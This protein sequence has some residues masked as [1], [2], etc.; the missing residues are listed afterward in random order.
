MASGAGQRIAEALAET[1]RDDRETALLV[2]ELAVGWAAGALVGGTPESGDDGA[3]ALA[4]LSALDDALTE[5]PALA[6]ALPVLLESARAGGQLRRSAEELT[7]GLAALAE[8]VTAERER[9][10]GLRAGEAA[11]R[12]RVAEHEELRR[13]AAELER[14]TRLAAQAE[15]L[16]AQRAEIGARLDALRARD[17]EAADRALRTD[18]ESLLRLTG[19]QLALLAPRTREALEEVAATQ[20]ELADT[21]QRLRESERELDAL[22]RKLTEVR[23]AYEP[24]FG[25]L[26]R[27]ARADHE[28][29]AAL[30]AAADAGG[31][32]ADGG[33]T[34]AEVAAL[35]ATV[36]RRLADADRALSRAL[37]K[38]RGPE[39][40]GAKKITG[41]PAA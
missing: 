10:D 17:P 1:G 26:A 28:L 27:H 6:G 8:R 25:A 9:L 18:A 15:A 5:V 12:A 21:E 4:V 14:L 40:D 23:T 16:G 13:E 22:H 41:S 3:E 7:A 38:R 24:S 34:L 39:A 32:E 31:E 19:E 11:L 2:L 33:L 20:R 35:T 30:R 29:A 37:A 36:E